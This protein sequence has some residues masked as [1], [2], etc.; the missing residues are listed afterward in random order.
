MRSELVEE[1]KK[2]GS[3]GAR[4]GTDWSREGERIGVTQTI[5]KDK[6]KQAQ[7]RLSTLEADQNDRRK[8]Y[9]QAESER[10]DPSRIVKALSKGVDDSVDPTQQ[11]Q[12]W[13]KACDE[14]YQNRRAASQAWNKWAEHQ[15]ELK[16]TRSEVYAFNKVSITKPNI[17]PAAPPRRTAITWEQPALEDRTE[18]LHLNNVFESTGANSNK[19]FGFSS[20]DP[21]LSVM[22]VSATL[23]HGQVSHYIRQYFETP[24]P[25]GALAGNLYNKNVRLDY[26][27]FV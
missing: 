23:T 26:E 25:F 7:E 15:S 21:G 6:A 17:E 12:A 20:D 2:K 8:A 13:H 10:L 14:L 9:L 18:S 19:A 11:D 16:S 4:G 27:I 1:R 5:A 3:K 22:Q 24:N